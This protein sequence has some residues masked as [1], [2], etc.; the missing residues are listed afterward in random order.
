[1][2]FRYGA[3]TSASSEEK[4]TGPKKNGRTGLLRCPALHFVLRCVRV[5]D[6]GMT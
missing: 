3:D 2:V 5:C 4:F 1:M 6:E